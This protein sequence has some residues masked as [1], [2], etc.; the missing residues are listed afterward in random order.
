MTRMRI[1]LPVTL[2]ALSA[3]LPSLTVAGRTLDPRTI[4]TDA[5][6]V[7]YAVT[8]ALREWYREGDTEELEYVA[9]TRAARA[10][11][12]LLAAE[13]ATPQGA[14]AEGR[15]RRAVL[16]ADVPD[17]DARPASGTDVA[18]VRLLAPLPFS[19]LAALHVDEL[20]VEG[21]V[22]A[23]ATV[24]RAAL[25]GDADARFA[26]DSLDDHELLWYAV[27]EIGFLLS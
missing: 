12:Q 11:L 21:E 10:S 8:P 24:A 4:V 19:A 18:E 6:L 9:L 26:V 7:A 22:M 5:G 25:D 13:L 27:Q 16:A 17:S 3:R 2:A 15:I 1:Y 14:V 23:A 20:A